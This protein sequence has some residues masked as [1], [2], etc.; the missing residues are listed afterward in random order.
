MKAQ[1]G[2]E[3]ATSAPKGHLTVRVKTNAVRCSEFRSIS[4]KFDR[5]TSPRKGALSCAVQASC[6][7][8]RW[9][10]FDLLRSVYIVRSNFITSSS[11]CRVPGRI[12]FLESMARETWAE[13]RTGRNYESC[14][15]IYDF[16]YPGESGELEWRSVST[17]PGV[18]WALSSVTSGVLRTRG[19]HRADC[20]SRR[21]GQVLLAVRGFDHAIGPLPTSLNRRGAVSRYSRAK[22]GER[23]AV[24]EVL[25]VH[26]AGENKFPQRGGC[27]QRLAPWTLRASLRALHA[28][29]GCNCL[30]EPRGSASTRMR[31]CAV[32]DGA[33]FSHT[34]CAECPG[35]RSMPCTR[36]SWRSRVVCDAR[37]S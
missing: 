27:L 8:V 24:D 26:V 5:L 11:S 23:V 18:P 4:A 29:T 28:V 10:R 22:H 19:W 30:D 25:D 12:Y 15:Q 21:R 6:S 13:T 7:C 36:S 35:V 33:C 17:V 20:R 3:A 16:A 37:A 34:G 32:T 2:V 9:V 14:P 1:N 31:R